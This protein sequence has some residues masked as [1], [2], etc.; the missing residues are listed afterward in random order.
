MEQL[1]AHVFGDYILQSDWMAAKKRGSLAVATIHALAYS[2]P[3]LFLQPSFAAWYF[4]VVTHAL[5]DH[6]GLAR[7][8]CFAKN[9]LAP[10]SEWPKWEDTNFSGYNKSKDLWMSTW[11]YIIADNGLHLLA[12]YCALRWL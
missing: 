2:L 3:F 1:I 7:Y 6:L 8:L 5:I 10:R 9:F 4:I 11:L 12:N